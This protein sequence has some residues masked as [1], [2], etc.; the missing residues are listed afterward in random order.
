MKK[1]LFALVVLWM[2]ALTGLQAQTINNGDKFW[3]GETLYTANT[4]GNGMIVLMGFNEEGPSRLLILRK[5]GDKAGEYVMMPASEDD[6]PPYGCLFGSRVEYIRQ[7]D[8]NFLA[9]YPEEHS[10]GQTAVLTPDDLQNCIAQ[11]QAVE[12]EGDPMKLCSSW[13]MNQNYIKGLH[14]EVLQRMLNKLKDKKKKSI[15]EGTNQDLI[16][17]IL[18]IGEAAVDAEPDGNENEPIVEVTVSDE[19]SFIANLRSNRLIR[20]AN[21]TVLNLSNVLNDESFF[22]Q[23][24]R[25]WLEDYY[26]AREGEEELLVSCDRFDG[27]QLDLVN[28]NNLTIVGGKECSIIVEPRYAN[29][30]NFYRCHNIR[31]E[32]LTLGHTEEGYCEG[33]VILAE[34][35]EHIVIDHCELFGCGTYGLEIES[36]TT[37]IMQNSII[38]DCS[39]GIMQLRDTHFT[40]FIDCDF[41]RCREFDLVGIG[42]ESENTRFIRCRFA[43]NQGE[44]FNLYS[45]VRLES[46]EIHHPKALSLGKVNELEYGDDQTRWF[47]DSEPLEVKEDI[48]PKKSN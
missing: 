47:R 17:Y 45:K 8:M 35:C 14:P 43:Q 30:L 4:N 16:A 1:C 23:D 36:T 15:I 44:L 31:L 19:R 5:E 29:V 10:I 40:S 11:Q 6:K 42:D 7:D 39:Y 20:I 26:K 46:C 9:F 34:N 38:R 2:A 3:D 37:L 33:G 18:A 22:R 27:R 25:K 21:G 13:L 41:V 48:G 24:G 28:V 32:N 12:E